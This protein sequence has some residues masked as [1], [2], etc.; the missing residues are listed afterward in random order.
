MASVGFKKFHSAQTCKGVLRHC[1]PVQR[2]ATNHKNIH[3]DKSKIGQNM[4]FVD[5]TYKEACKRYDERLKELDSTTNKNKRC[6]RVTMFG[7]IVETPREMTED[8]C[9]DFF[10]EAFNIMEKK[11]GK[12][13]II[14]AYAHF[15][16]QHEYLDSDANYRHAKPH[17]HCYV[18]PEIDGQLRG[19]EFSNLKN[20]QSINQELDRLCRERY[21][22]AYKGTQ[23]EKVQWKDVATLKNISRQ[24]EQK[25][26]E[27]V[28]ML[29]EKI[30]QLEG[31][32]AKAMEIKEQIADKDGFV[33]LPYDE[34]MTIVQTAKHVDQITSTEQELETERQ[35]QAQEQ[36]RINQILQ[37]LELDQIALQK[38]MELLEQEKQKVKEDQEKKAK[39][40]QIM[41]E[42]VIQN[43]MDNINAF[44]TGREESMLSFMSEHTINGNNLKDVYIAEEQ[45]KLNKIK[46][47]YCR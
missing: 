32:I 12:E 34:Y 5:R 1:D 37:Q 8:Q 42:Q 35:R 18:I 41:A 28:Q 22:F 11:Y 13:N 23:K 4:M 46:D 20:I 10:K 30:K 27:K 2:L 33:R 45:H 43:A 38:E 24:V 17:L 3:I 14:G 26:R 6:D 21:H 19:R 15:D 7:L 47:D 39:E 16:E 31:R 36:E 25:Q 9:R 29:T 44:K 40:Q